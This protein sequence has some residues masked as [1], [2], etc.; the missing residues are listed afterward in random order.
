MKFTRRHFFKTAVAVTVASPL[1]VP[2]SAFAAGK[3]VGVA[4]VGAGGHATYL[5]DSWRNDPRVK[6]LYVTD[7]DIGRAK[8]LCA[9]IEKKTGYRPEAL[10]DFRRTLDD[11][12]VDAICCA[13]CNHWHAL[14]A[15]WA[16]QAGKHCYIEKPISYCLAEGKAMTAA[17]KKSGLVFQS[18]TQRRS[19]TNVNELVDFIR[20]G[21][22]GEVKLARVVGYRPRKTI[23]PPGDYPIPDGVDY[24]FWSGPVPVKPMT[25]PAFHYDWHFQRLYGNGDLGN[26]CSHRLDIAH[27]ALGLNGFPKSVVTY[28]GRMGYDVETK[29]P[30][31]HDAGD[32]A[33]TSTTIYN[34]GDKSIICEVRG[35]E[36]PPYFPVEKKV[37][38][39]IGIVFYGTDGYGFQAPHGRGNINSMSCACDLKGNITKEFKSLDAAGKIAPTEDAHNRHIAN[40]LDAI[41]ANDPKTVTTN[42][43]TGE[44]QAALAHLGNISYYLGEN[45]KVSQDE[46]KRAVQKLK[47]AD[48]NEATLLRMLEHIEA[49]GVDLKRTPLSLGA[50]L[51]IDIEKEVFIGNDQATAL[52]T[53]EYRKPFVVPETI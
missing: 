11:K 42:A 51:D 25:R 35:L 48:D 6:I 31:Y 38:S 45:N 50:T 36:S 22:I 32:T 27:W 7:P 26:Q 29:N 16:L 15:I 21:G 14:T 19:T 40:F 9:G 17:A 5:S 43:R 46:L 41:A 1:I 18:G 20:N 33:N 39:M 24:D 49:S 3:R 28:G 23:G 10:V 53:R 2:E 8:K 13:T 12:S 4:L 44:I 37:G 34:Y 52:M 47:S 30:N